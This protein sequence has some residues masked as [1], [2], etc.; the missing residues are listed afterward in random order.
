MEA[1]NRRRH[2]A[3]VGVALATAAA[4]ALI[5]ALL[6]NIFQRKQEA[7]SPFLKRWRSPRA[8]WTPARWGTNWPRQ[9]D[10]YLRTSEPTGTK[11]GGALVGPEGTL[12]PQKA[13]RDPWLKR[14]FAGYLFAV[15]Y[16]DRRGHAFMLQDQELTKRNVPGEDKQSGNCLHCHSSIMPL[17][18]KLGA[19][20]LPQ[21]SEAEQVQAGLQK[22][23]ELGYWDAHQ[24]L[25][26]VSGG[27]AHPV[28]CVDCHSPKTKEL[29]VTRPGF[30]AGI[31][32]LAAG[33]APVPHLPS[34]ERW[35]RGDRAKPY[36]PNVDGPPGDALLRLRPMPRR[37][38]LRQG[39]DALLPW[40]MA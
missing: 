20:A 13:E 40:A 1:G 25:A 9:Y 37:V 16:R 26:Q 22:V 4:T 32:K 8:T 12:P 19:E 5:T 31:Q 39:P 7:K 29:R 3:L 2:F 30:L 14:I 11:Y 38:L 33:P 24:A 36:D 21:A 35:R 15:D 27:K 6:L 34:V 23:G 18:R 10:G 28:S 17:Y